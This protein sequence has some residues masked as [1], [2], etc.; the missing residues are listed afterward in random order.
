MVLTT[1]DINIFKKYGIT[2]IISNCNK[3][4]SKDK[5]L[6]VNSYLVTCEKENEQWYDIIMGSRYS[7]FDA[8]YDRFGRIV[9]KIE[10]TDGRINPRLW[11]IKP[12]ED[13]KRR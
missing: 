12:K 9:K 8:Y 2:V 11:D 7:I 1:E 3:S 13:K 4:A 5:S 6:P 10:W